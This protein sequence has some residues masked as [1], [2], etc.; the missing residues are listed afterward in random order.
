MITS[1]KKAYAYSVILCISMSGFAGYLKAEFIDPLDIAAEKHS[2]LLDKPLIGSAHKGDVSIVVG[3]T[4][5]IMASRDLGHTWTQSVVPVQ[6]DLVAVDM[7]SEDKG[8]AV[9]H[10]GVILFTKDGGINW[11]KQLDG[12]MAAEQFTHY[13]R[14]LAGNGDVEAGT[15]LELTE[16]NYRDG[17][18]LP[19]LDVWFRD[20]SEGFVVGAFGNIAYTNDSGATW[21]PLTHRIDNDAGLHLNSITGVNGDVYIGSERGTLFKLNKENDRFE[22]IETGYS[23]SFSGVVGDE[24]QVI[25]YGLLGTIYRSFDSGGSWERI[26]SITQSTINDAVALSDG[27]G[28]AFANQAGELILTDFELRKLKLYESEVSDGYTSVVDSNGEEF[29]VT[30][31]NGVKIVS[32]SDRTAITTRLQE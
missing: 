30:T 1:I 6:S 4:G 16:L 31:L 13:Y 19:Y 2:S 18:G 29:I 23:G 5:L 32:I 12:R 21:T 20:E 27:S 14:E 8:W 25:A 17:P 10:D 26:A 28:F 11:S 24:H 22:I 9:G 3:P 15:A 7:V